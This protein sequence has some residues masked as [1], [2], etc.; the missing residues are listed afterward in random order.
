MSYVNK[1]TYKF[2][3][4]FLK[5]AARNLNNNNR[6]NFLHRKVVYASQLENL[7]DQF[8]ELTSEGKF[9]NMNLKDSDGR[10][11]NIT[12]Y[13]K[14]CGMDDFIEYYDGNNFI[15]TNLGFDLI[16]E[17]EKDKMNFIIEIIGIAIGILSALGS[18]LAIFL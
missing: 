1:N 13:L 4:A 16:N 15:L 10:I 12:S 11:D 17:F 18:L 5:I 2:L 14:K 7:F 9:C 3:K 6:L 8:P